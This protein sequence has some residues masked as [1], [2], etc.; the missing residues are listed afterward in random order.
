[1]ETITSSSTT[2]MRRP[3]K[4]PLSGFIVVVHPT[5]SLVTRQDGSQEVHEE[6]SH[7]LLTI[8]YFLF[9]TKGDTSPHFR[10]S[11]FIGMLS[12][13]TMNDCEP[14]LAHE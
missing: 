12:G 9:F 6:A 4:R 7:L 1:M 13:T 10:H 3:R 2:R 5:H 11:T 14:H 8:S